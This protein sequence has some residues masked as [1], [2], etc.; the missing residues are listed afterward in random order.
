VT[1]LAQQV[2]DHETQL[3]P[4]ILVTLKVGTLLGSCQQHTSIATQLAF[5]QPSLPDI[6]LA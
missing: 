6:Q 3:S 1:L 2:A 5:N 4:N